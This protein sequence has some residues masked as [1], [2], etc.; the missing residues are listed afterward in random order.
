MA[1]NDY[2]I[3][4]FTRDGMTVEM[5]MYDTNSTLE[6][7]VGYIQARMRSKDVAPIITPNTAVS[8]DYSTV[9]TFHVHKLRPNDARISFKVY[10]TPTKDELNA[11]QS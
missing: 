10:R 4:L 5:G 1:A 2:N 6:Q 3:V 11:A 8:V 7:V 9:F